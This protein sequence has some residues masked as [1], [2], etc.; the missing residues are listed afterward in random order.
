MNN[1]ATSKH[2]TNNTL[3]LVHEIFSIVVHNITTGIRAR[4]IPTD[5]AITSPKSNLWRNPEKSTNNQPGN[6]SRIIN[7]N[8]SQPEAIMSVRS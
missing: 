7:G 4:E 3:I 1:I 2:A 5:N 8:T 6:Q